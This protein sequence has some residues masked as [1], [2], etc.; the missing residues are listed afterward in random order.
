MLDKLLFI[1]WFLTWSAG[2]LFFA[3]SAFRLPRRLVFGVGLALGAVMQ[4]WFANLLGFFLP[5]PVAFWGGALL[6]LALGIAFALPLNLDKIRHALLP[7]SWG[8]VLML[9]ILT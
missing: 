2:G 5:A 1:L 4:V 9:L 8:Q 6:T 3:S 7:A